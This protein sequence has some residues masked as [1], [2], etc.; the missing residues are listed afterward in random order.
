MGSRIQNLVEFYLAYQPQAA[1]LTERHNGLH[2]DILLKLLYTVLS[3]KWTEIW[4]QALILLNSQLH[5]SKHHHTYYQSPPKTPLLVLKGIPQSSDIREDA[6]H[7]H[8]PGEYSPYHSD[9]SIVSL[10]S[11]RWQPS[12]GQIVQYDPLI[13]ES[14]RGQI[15]TK[16]LRIMIIQILL[17]QKMTQYQSRI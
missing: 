2:I 15:P 10:S 11:T 6:T 8:S 16:F 3:P 9:Y 14:L 13:I 7:I 4:P 17:T 5:V 12:Q 1:G